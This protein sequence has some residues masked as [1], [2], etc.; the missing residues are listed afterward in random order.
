MILAGPVAIQP[1][2]PLSDPI[3][4]WSTRDWTGVAGPD[5]LPNLGSHPDADLA[6]YVDDRTIPE[7][8]NGNSVDYIRLAVR[9]ITYQSLVPNPGMILSSWSDLGGDPG[10]SPFTLLVAMSWSSN[11]AYELI[12]QVPTEAFNRFQMRMASGPVFTDPDFEWSVTV[13]GFVTLS[14]RAQ[15]A[16]GSYLLAQVAQR[17]AQEDHD[18]APQSRGDTFVVY[19]L[20]IDPSH[21]GN[22]IGRY[23]DVE[24]FEHITGE[25]LLT[26]GGASTSTPVTAATGPALL[27]ALP[28]P[29]IDV[30]MDWMYEGTCVAGN[31]WP[32]VGAGFF[33]GE[34]SEEDLAE[35]FDY[36]FPGDY[37]ATMPPFTRRLEVGDPSHAVYVAGTG[38]RGP[39]D[40][41]PTAQLVVPADTPVVHVTILPASGWYAGRDFTFA[42]N[43]GVGMAETVI[44]IP[45][46]EGD[47]LDFEVG[48]RGTQRSDELGVG[49]RPDGGQAGFNATSGKWGASGGGSSRIWKNGDLI[50]H[51]G[52]GGANAWPALGGDGQTFAGF[53][54]DRGGGFPGLWNGNGQAGNDSTQG[55]G[56]PLPMAGKGGTLTAGGAPGDQPFGGG[57]VAIT[58]ATAGVGGVGGSGAWFSDP[59]NP[60]RAGAPGGGGGYRGGGGSSIAGGSGGGSSWLHPICRIVHQAHTGRTTT[61]CRNAYMIVFY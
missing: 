39:S 19:F 25:T 13:S 3:F 10:D 18:A 2:Q 1:P 57:F 59:N 55:G 4:L 11:P 61:D 53:N 7:D 41:P 27:A 37:R 15:D 38:Q 16:A 60:T 52:A 23:N 56:T 51:I 20:T 22:C 30:F 50:A 54:N 14:T 43:E 6:V 35:W 31:P 24:G 34:P 32:V 36:W 42:D 26:V 44:E 9:G 40:T 46:V 12:T 5:A 45:V 48:N 28:S 29:Q 17:V 33:R 58:P 47:V 49:G 8:G 21:G